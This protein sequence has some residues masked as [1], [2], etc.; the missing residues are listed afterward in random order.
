MNMDTDMRLKVSSPTVGYYIKAKAQS[1]Q[2]LEIEIIVVQ[3]VDFGVRV[4]GYQKSK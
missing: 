1:H 4:R 3:D 2:L